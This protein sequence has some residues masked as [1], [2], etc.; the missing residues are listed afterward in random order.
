MFF[1]LVIGEPQRKDL[2]SM[3]YMLIDIVFNRSHLEMSF[4]VI[5]NSI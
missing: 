3:P 4:N 1:L 5:E 2:F